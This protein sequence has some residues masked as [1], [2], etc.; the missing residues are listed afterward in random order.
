M[1]A[2]VPASNGKGRGAAR[3][4]LVFALAIL[5]VAAVLLVWRAVTTGTAKAGSAVVDFGYEITDTLPLDVDHTYH[6]DVGEFLVHIQVKDG[7]ASF[8]ESECPDHVCE[9]T[10][11]W[12]ENPGDWACC[13]PAGVYLEIAE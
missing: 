6:Y 2:K 10:F 9:E 11:G 12:L 7:K 1:S 4:D 5:A 3:T 8:V 13:M